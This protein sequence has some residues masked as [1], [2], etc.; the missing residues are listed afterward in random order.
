M[1][2]DTL[3]VLLRNYGWGIVFAWVLYREVWPWLRDRLV[4][5]YMED[6][7][8]R[9]RRNDELRN[10]Q[11]KR[12]ADLEERQCAAFEQVASAVNEM[13]KNIMLTNER[14]T[15]ILVNQQQ[16]MNMYDLHDRKMDR[17]IVKMEVRSGSLTPQ[18]AKVLDEEHD[19]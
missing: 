1:Q 9:E 17:A 8:R 12:L 3:D 10:V 2:T 18:E 5:S 13:S 11:E 7:K 4:P 19:H 6:R 15:L 14:L 16:L